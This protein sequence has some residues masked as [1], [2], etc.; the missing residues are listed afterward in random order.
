M[1]TGDQR[2][3]VRDEHQAARVLIVEAACP[4]HLL[5]RRVKAPNLV[6]DRLVKREANVLTFAATLTQHLMRVH[7]EDQRNVKKEAAIIFLVSVFD[8]HQ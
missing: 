7:L 8:L 4:G 3:D 6:V 1:G 5:T 2:G